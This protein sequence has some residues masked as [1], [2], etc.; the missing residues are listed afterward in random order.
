MFTVLVVPFALDVGFLKFNL[1]IFFCV[2]EFIFRALHVN[3][4]SSMVLKTLSGAPLPSVGWPPR[5]PQEECH[6]T[7]SYPRVPFTYL[8]A[9]TAHQVG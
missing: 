7:L 9:F 8:V 6:R 3:L 5:L 4:T 2:C 1:F